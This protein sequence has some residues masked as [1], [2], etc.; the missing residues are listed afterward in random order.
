MKGDRAVEDKE[1]HCA[2]DYNMPLLHGRARLS[3]F[4]D[5]FFKINVGHCPTDDNEIFVHGFIFTL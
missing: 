5:E 2:Y 1:T 3:I 4:R